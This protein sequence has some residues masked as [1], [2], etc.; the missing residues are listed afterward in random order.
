MQ[1]AQVQSLAREGSTRR[2]A[3]SPHSRAHEL[4]LLNLRDLEPVLCNQ[5]CQRNKKP[6]HRN[7]E[8]PLLAATRESPG[9]A[10]EIQSNQNQTNK[11]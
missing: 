11:F 6:S 3:S 2:G 5:R 7:Q 9:V 4:Q 8:W 10:T 1:G